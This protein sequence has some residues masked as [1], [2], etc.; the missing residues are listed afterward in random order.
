MI[1]SLF[2]PANMAVN[3]IGVF[4]GML[5][6]IRFEIAYRGVSELLDNIM[7]KII[8]S[9]CFWNP[10]GNI[11]LYRPLVIIIMDEFVE[12]LLKTVDTNMFRI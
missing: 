6:S 3:K 1:Y 5:H 12:L 9:R 8:N 11:K 4:R 10:F 7:S 2:I